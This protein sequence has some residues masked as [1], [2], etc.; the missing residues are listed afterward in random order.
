MS[1]AKIGSRV[2]VDPVC[3]KPSSSSKKRTWSAKPKIYLDLLT[4]NLKFKLSTSDSGKSISLLIFS[5]F[6]TVPRLTG[7]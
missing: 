5:C 6:S 7:S 4:F 1:S 3:D 2:D